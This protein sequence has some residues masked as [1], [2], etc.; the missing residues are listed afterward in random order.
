MQLALLGL[1]LIGGSLGLA[2]K[3]AG[4]DWTITGWDRDP[5][6]APAALARGAI[7]HV[8]ASAVE[9]VRE[10]DLVLLSIPVTAMHD[11]LA[12]LGP[13]LKP[14][15]VVTDVASTKAAV[16]GWARAVLPSGIHFVGG[17]PM[18]GTEHSGITHARPGMF[19][20]AVYVLTPDADTPQEALAPLEEL[21]SRVGAHAVR[22]TPETHDAHVAA[23]SHLPFLLSTLLVR[24]TTTDPAWPEAK[25]LAATGYQSTSRLAS[26]N[27][28]MYRGICL[29][30]AEQIRPWLL[31]MA[32]DLEDLAGHLED[33]AYLD[34]LFT[35]AK[36]A[37]DAWN[38]EFEQARENRGIM[39]P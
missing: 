10:A 4:S 38:A 32:R 14:G 34:D 12:E 35:G 39:Q 6:A 13:H 11:L 23:V 26:G 15:A 24:R 21:V 17:H 7:D 9:A 33:A 31:A 18:A 29:T 28:A 5:E 1:G 20:G 22:M 16:T 30:N 25:R 36:Q 27:E 2:L 8:A 3:A 19:R 37:R